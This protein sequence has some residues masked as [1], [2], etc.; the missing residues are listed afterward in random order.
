MSDAADLARTIRAVR[1]RVPLDA[2]QLLSRETPERVAWVLAHLPTEFADRVRAYLPEELRLH[3]AED[4]AEQNVEPAGGGVRDMMEPALA[5]L[6]ATA[7]V[8]DAI[9]FLRAHPAPRQITY[10]YVTDGDE[11]LSGMIVIRDLLLA[12][13]TE[14]LSDVMLPDPFALALDTVIGEALQSA[15]RRHYPVYPVVDGERR[16]AGV[17][18][19][20]RLFERQAIEISAQSGQMVG[21][22]KE[23]RVGSGIWTAFT[24]RHPWLQV[25]LITAFGAGLVVS[26]FESTITQIV[27]LAAFLPVLAGQSGNTGCQAL[28]ITLRGMTL[29]DL[30]QISVLRLL[31]KELALGAMNGFLTGAIAA[32]AMWWMASRDGN[33]DALLLG[34]V[35]W[36]A[37]IGACML[38]G[39]FGV[40]VPLALRRAG[41]DPVTASS[42]L[43][44]TG[45]DIAGMGLMLVLVSL[46]V[47]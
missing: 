46:L 19:G 44:T 4:A 26:L 25:N 20:W 24:L 40:L 21:V 29:G 33:A 6:P 30:E 13:P 38:S 5:V 42:I 43:L 34:G 7:T 23:E 28:A 36:L 10:V 45:T 14:P 9:D 22:A 47:L 31:R 3:L 39:L 35:I 8:Q 41:A 17:I 37:M 32:L 27:A 18:R 1:A 12:D 15:I 2:A 11:K 16:L